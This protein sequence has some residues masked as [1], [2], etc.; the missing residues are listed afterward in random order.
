MPKFLAQIDP[1]GSGVADFV[2]DFL[3]SNPRIDG[4]RLVRLGYL[5]SAY[6]D[7]SDAWANIAKPIC[8][9]AEAFSR[10]VRERTYF[11][12][13]RKQTPVLTSM[14]GEVADWYV[15]VRDDAKHLL[16][17]TPDESPLKDYRRWALRRAEDDLRREEGIAEEV[18][19]D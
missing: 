1:T 12:L 15:Q 5:G 8:Q 3:A 14:P 18:T 4:D 11:G 19:D 16:E 9:K 6:E 10:D 17:L 13:A 7:T 2:N